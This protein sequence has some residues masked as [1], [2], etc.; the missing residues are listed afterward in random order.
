[1]SC[2]R[3]TAVTDFEPT[4]ARKAFPCF[5]HPSM[6]AKFIINIIRPAKY[7]AVSNEELIST[8]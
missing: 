2:F 4:D 3:N 8:K 1:M 6:K 5:D 7:F